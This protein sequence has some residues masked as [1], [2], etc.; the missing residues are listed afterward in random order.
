MLASRV[1]D[2]AFRVHRANGLDTGLLINFNVA[3]ISDGTRRIVSI[4][5]LD[6]LR[7]FVSSW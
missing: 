1:V 4:F 7:A 2:A 6:F 3:V 5:A